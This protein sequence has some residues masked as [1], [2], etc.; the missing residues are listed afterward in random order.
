[1][2][3]V[4]TVLDTRWYTYRATLCT[5]VMAHSFT[6]GVKCSFTKYSN[7]KWKVKVLYGQIGPYLPAVETLLRSHI[8]SCLRYTP[9]TIS[10]HLAK[11]T[12]LSQITRLFEYDICT[13]TP[14]LSNFS[15]WLLFRTRVQ[16]RSQKFD[17]RKPR[18]YDHKTFI[19]ANKK[20]TNNKSKR[21]TYGK[22]SVL[23]GRIWSEF[24]TTNLY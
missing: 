3:P 8:A 16:T 21:C 19:L 22:N 23:I 11:I 6:P 1:M 10:T 12:L 4:D 13:R 14:L 15:D 7:G 20:Q 18:P 24:D 17:D 2:A 5:H 9:T